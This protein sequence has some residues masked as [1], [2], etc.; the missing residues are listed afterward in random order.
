MP[1]GTDRK[2]INEGGDEETG[3]GGYGRVG[4]RREDTESCV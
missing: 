3:K 2:W 1:D 4:G